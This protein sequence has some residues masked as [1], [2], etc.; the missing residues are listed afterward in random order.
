[1]RKA[2]STPQTKRTETYP[3]NGY[4]DLGQ[5][6]QLRRRHAISARAQYHDTLT[7]QLGWRSGLSVRLEVLILAHGGSVHDEKERVKLEPPNGCL[8]RAD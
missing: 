7:R 5:G 1:L 2:Q 3:S 6:R 4:F 8:G